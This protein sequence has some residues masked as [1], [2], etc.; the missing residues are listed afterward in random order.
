[1]T[2][3]GLSLPHNPQPISMPPPSGFSWVDEPRLAAM[4]NPSSPEE[5]TWLRRH[6]I[7]V[8]VSLTED[9]SAPAALGQ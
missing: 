9:P 7:E 2:A 1:M 5:L 3:F 8:I 4:A 6:G